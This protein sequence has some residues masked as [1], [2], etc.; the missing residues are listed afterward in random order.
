MKRYPILAAA[1]LVVAVLSAQALAA[2]SD[3]KPVVVVKAPKFGAIL[4]TQGHLALYTWFKEKDK[5]VH[6]TGA[7]RIHLAPGHCP[8]RDDGGQ[9]RCRRDGN[10]RDDRSPRR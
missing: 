10:V 3:A 8:E 6:C 2:R 4:A 5:K 7:A 1:F 9:A